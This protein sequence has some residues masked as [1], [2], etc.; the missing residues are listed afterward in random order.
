[1]PLSYF[2]ALLYFILS[3]NNKTYMAGLEGFGLSSHFVRCRAADSF[4]FASLRPFEPL[5]HAIGMFYSHPYN[6]NFQITITTIYGR[7]GGI[8]TPNTRFWRPMLYRLEL[9]PYLVSLC[10]VCFLHHLQYFF[11][12]ILSGSFFLFLTLA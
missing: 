7:A 4:R 10:T 12:S 9:Q 2:P 3:N 8:R 6:F 11:I 5:K 1:M